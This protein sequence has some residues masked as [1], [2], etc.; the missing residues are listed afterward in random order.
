MNT[1][2]SIGEIATMLPPGTKEFEV[3]DHPYKCGNDMVIDLI[4]PDIELNTKI[5]TTVKNYIDGLFQ[6]P[7]LINFSSRPW[8]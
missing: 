5:R 3:S 2:V 6:R 4:T 7:V 8:N 1:H